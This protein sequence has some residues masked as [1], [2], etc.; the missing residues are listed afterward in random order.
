MLQCGGR[1]SLVAGH[2]LELVLELFLDEG[3]LTVPLLPLGKEGGGGAQ[4]SAD[5]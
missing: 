2:G 1:E 5:D 4:E 3:Y